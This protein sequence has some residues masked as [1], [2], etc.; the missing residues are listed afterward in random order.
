MAPLTSSLLSSVSPIISGEDGYI[1]ALNNWLLESQQHYVCVCACMH[2]CV[3][4][5]SPVTQ[6]AEVYH[7]FLFAD[8][9]STVLFL[10]MCTPA[11]AYICVRLH[12][13]LGQATGT[14]GDQK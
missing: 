14:H 6:W 2:V 12:A 5:F 13:N 9:L 11:C 3:C 1:C 4:V 10:H 8:M 7:T